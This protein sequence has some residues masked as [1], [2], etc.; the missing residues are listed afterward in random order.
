MSANNSSGPPQANASTGPRELR[1]GL[2]REA[3][4]WWTDPRLA[5]AAG[6]ADG[7]RL[8][9]DACDQ[10]LIRALTIALGGTT[11]KTYRDAAR[12]HLTRADQLRERQQWDRSVLDEREAA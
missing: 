5:Y 1:D 10:A 2:W 3:T 6:L 4:D 7:Y 12:T 9:Y 8:G 11:A